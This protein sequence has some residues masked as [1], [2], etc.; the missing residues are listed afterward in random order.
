MSGWFAFGE[1]WLPFLLGGVPIALLIWVV[2]MSV[3]IVFGLALAWMRVYGGKIPYWFATGYVEFF[4]GTPVIVQM[5]FIYF[6]LPSLGISFSP[7]VAATIAIALDT[8]A[9]QAEYFRGSIQAVSKGQLIAARAQGMTALQ[10]FMNI[11]LPQALRLVLPQ[12]SNEAIIE[13]KFTSIAYTI[14]VAEITERAYKVG[15]ETYE[16]FAIFLWAA[17]IYMVLTTVVS[18]ALWLL[19]KR[20]AIPGLGVNVGRPEG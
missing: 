2:A 11:V 13:L 10:A 17:V 9:Y 1:K 14:G 16:F 3:G 12:W 15:Y 7:F 8:S 5:F 18:E 20:L 6:G 19:E 4:R